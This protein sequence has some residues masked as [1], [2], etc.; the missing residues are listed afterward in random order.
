V[1]P[2]RRSVVASIYRVTPQT[3]NPTDER[4]SWTLVFEQRSPVQD[5]VDRERRFGTLN[6]TGRPEQPLAFA[7]DVPPKGASRA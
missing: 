5:Y 6:D 4:M 2:P 7:S 3:I 1:R